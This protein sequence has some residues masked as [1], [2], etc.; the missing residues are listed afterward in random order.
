MISHVNANITFK[1]LYPTCFNVTESLSAFIHPHIIPLV[2]FV[3]VMRREERQD[4][5]KQVLFSTAVWPLD[6]TFKTFTTDGFI[7]H[8][9]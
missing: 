9:C 4:H 7:N 3:Q 8:L 6:E 5:S 2:G 1:D